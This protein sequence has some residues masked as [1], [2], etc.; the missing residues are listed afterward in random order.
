MLTTVIGSVH[1][2]L[3]ACVGGRAR[4]GQVLQTRSGGQIGSCPHT[5][6]TY[7]PYKCDHLC[8]ASQRYEYMYVCKGPPPLS[9]TSRCL[10]C[11]SSGQKLHGQL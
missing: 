11:K 6:Q 1:V 5:R 8:A 2:G 10:L 7:R 3:F 9:G 4:P